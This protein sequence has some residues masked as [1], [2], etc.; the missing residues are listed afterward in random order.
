[1]KVANHK[2]ENI[3]GPL[4]P[5][6]PTRLLWPGL[7]LL[8]SLLKLWL[9]AGVELGKDEAAYWHWG[10]HLD[11]TYALLPFGILR[12]AHALLPY[13]EWFLRLPSILSSTLAT[14]L[15]YRLCRL[16]PLSPERARWAATLFATSHWV[17]HTG[18]YLHPDGFLVTCWLLALYW[19]RLAIDQQTPVAFAKIGLAIGLAILC[20]YSAAF[21][22]APL[23]LWILLAHPARTRYRFFL[24]ALIPALLVAAPLIHAQLQTDFYLPF[25]LSS[26]SRIAA[27][28]PLPLRLLHFLFN[29]L[30]FV[31]PLLL[32]LL[33]RAWGASLLDLFRERNSQNLLTLLPALTPV[34]AFAFF[35]LFRGQIKGNW[36]LP[37]FLGLW[38][39]AFSSRLL[40][41][42]TR[43]FSIAALAVG[44]IHALTV[45]FALRYPGSLET[46]ANDLGDSRLNATYVRLVSTPDQQR[47]PTFSWTERL[48]EYHDWSGLANRFDEL[49]DRHRIP[50][51]TPLV[52]TQYGIPFSLS[53]YSPTRRSYYTVDDP[54]FRH[55]TD[56]H[57]R[58]GAEAS[59][60]LLFLVRSGSPIPTSLQELYPHRQNL[61]PISRIPPDCRPIAYT[62]TLLHR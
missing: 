30:F 28:H 49:L 57:E 43:T 41:L 1:M 20:K 24:S 29:P 8:C 39:L 60:Q 55:L 27:E 5:V 26:L 32:Y 52:S 36:I 25:T 3:N 14:L 11:A 48:G 46:I 40:P 62:I 22:A 42:R 19:A 47:E 31:S 12:L 59:D 18:S 51:S 13:Q 34:A 54:R 38:P 7:L 37:A 15:L 4:N 17:W 23:F 45:A 16:H 53:F 21:L 56:F 9:V 58:T 6:N 35:A 50:A 2:V 33:Y 44:L 61:G 10:Q